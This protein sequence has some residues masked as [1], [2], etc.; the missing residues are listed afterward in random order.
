M[1]DTL[2]KL[3]PLALFCAAV[4]VACI[5]ALWFVGLCALGRWLG[6]R[7][8]ADY[9]RGGMLEVR[10]DGHVVPAPRPFDWQEHDFEWS[11]SA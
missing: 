11:E 6:R 7:D 9:R 3:P 1:I 5:L 10:P 8:I 2:L 4:C